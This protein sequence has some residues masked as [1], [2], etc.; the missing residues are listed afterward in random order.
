MKQIWTKNALSRIGK[1]RPLI[2]V[3]II[4][5]SL[6]LILGTTFAWFASSASVINP[7]R[8]QEFPFSFKIE[9]VWIPPIEV[10]PGDS[11]EKEVSVKNTGEQPGFVRVLVHTEIISQEGNPL[12]ANPSFITF[13]DIAAASDWVYADGYWYY[14]HVL[15]PGETTPNIFAGV[16]FAPGLPSEYKNAGMNIDVKVEATETKQWSYRESWW[17]TTA[18]P[19]APFDVIDDALAALATAS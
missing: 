15:E 19:S 5:I 2:L 11:I 8:T 13:D 9:E 3:S 4:I 1:Q 7:F 12:A 18:A 14:L 17:N 10:E 16:T 6:L